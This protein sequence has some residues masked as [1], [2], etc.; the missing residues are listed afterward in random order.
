MHGIP[1]KKSVKHVLLKVAQT[2][3]TKKNWETQFAVPV[4]TATFL[5]TMDSIVFMTV[6]MALITTLLKNCV[7]LA[8]PTAHFVQMETTAT[9]VKLALN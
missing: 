3:Y 4:L 1:S 6:M 7:F 9:S 5:P 2:A 8:K